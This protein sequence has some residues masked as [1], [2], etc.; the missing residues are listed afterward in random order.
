MRSIL[1]LLGRSPFRPLAEHAER[2]H[3]TVVLLRPL[4]DAFVAERW[5]DLAGHFAEIRRLEHEA[6]KLKNEIRD[7]LPSSI[8]LPVDRGDI[9][10]FLKEQDS[11]ADRAEELAILLDMRRTPT[12]AEM[13]DAVLGFVD[14]V[15][16][17]SELWYA[18]ARDLPILQE[19]SFSG[20]K[21]RK[22]MEQIGRISEME[23]EAEQLEVSISK[24]LFT[25][26]EQVGPITVMLWMRILQRIGAVANHAENTADH[27]RLMLARR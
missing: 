6:D 9:L 25:L 16:A 18:V 27:L 26:E 19:T 23:W 13:R 21:V 20:P 22:T 1:E 14:H 17:T 3:E 24:T 4:F 12:P 15:I 8:L 5:T 7:H 2:C 11:I 10:L